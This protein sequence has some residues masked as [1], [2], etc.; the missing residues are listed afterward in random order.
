MLFRSVEIFKNKGI[1]PL[2]ISGSEAWMGSLF[3]MS[4]TLSEGS[5]SVSTQIAKNNVFFKRRP[6]IRGAELFKQLIDLEPW[7]EGY[8]NMSATESVYNFARGEAAMMVNGSWASTTIDDASRSMV[9]GKVKVMPFP[10]T[11]IKLIDEGVAG[12]SDGFVLS[13]ESSLTDVSVELFYIEIMRA[14][15]D[16][17][18]LEKG[19]GLPVY[20]SQDL[21]RTNFTTL[22]KCY[23][24]FPKNYYHRYISVYISPRVFIFTINIEMLPS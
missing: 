21:E 22:K 7:Q 9:N 24:V 6:F 10:V 19:M 17:A 4:L 20:Q 11:K 16:K 1:T 23:N 2:A 12:Y 15:S 14:I 13:K 3:Y 18:V 5:V 8:E